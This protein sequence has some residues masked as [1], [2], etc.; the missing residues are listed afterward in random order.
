M[1]RIP[2]K[3]RGR[4]CCSEGTLEEKIAWPEGLCVV[5]SWDMLVEVR[6]AFLGKGRLSIGNLCSRC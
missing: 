3:G 1:M 5:M 2:P 6:I 4:S